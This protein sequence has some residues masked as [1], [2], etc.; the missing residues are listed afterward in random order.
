MSLL[1]DEICNI[2]TS[3]FCTM[4]TGLLFELSPVTFLATYNSKSD[5]VK[6]NWAREL[7][8]FASYLFTVCNKSGVL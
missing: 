1:Y 7:S 5:Q 4:P 8:N 6:Q 3:T 2:F